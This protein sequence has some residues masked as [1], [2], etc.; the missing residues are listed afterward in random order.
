M[1]RGAQLSSSSG[2]LADSF[3]GRLWE[4]GPTKKEK[5]DENELVERETRE[6]NFFLFFSF[7]DLLYWS[8]CVIMLAI[9]VKVNPTAPLIRVL[10]LL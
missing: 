10:L 8:A 2:A 5:I 7:Y 4:T 6:M 3:R 1:V 9:L